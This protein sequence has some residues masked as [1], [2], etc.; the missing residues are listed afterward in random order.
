MIIDKND[1]LQKAKQWF[2][3]SIA[4]NHIKNTKKLANPKNLI[5]NPFL[6]KYLANFLTGNSNP[7]S[8]AQALLLPRGVGTSINTA[9]GTNMQTFTSTVLEGFGSVIPGIDIEFM[10][11]VDKEWKYCQLKA[12]PN[13][14]NKDDVE[15]IANHFKDV[16]NLAKQNRKRISFDDM[17]I[18]VIYGEE[19][20]LS[21][22]YKNITKKHHYPVIIGKEFWYRLTGDKDFYNDLINAIGSVACEANYGQELQNIISELAKSEKIQNL[23]NHE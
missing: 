10:D 3:N 9:V 16:I 14:I 15:T 7:E 22:H 20:D 23:N 18:G 4:Q 6:V 19:S 12:G 13:T 1:I 2:K 21:T 5:I 11:Q 8:I 17:V